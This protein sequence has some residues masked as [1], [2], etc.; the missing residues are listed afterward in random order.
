[1]VC[2]A[3]DSPVGRLRLAA[4][5]NGLCL[6]AFGNRADKRELQ[7]LA[8][9]CGCSPGKET[10]PHLQRGI[11]E[12]E[13]YFAAGLRDFIV[14]LDLRGTPFQIKVWRELLTIP[15]GRTLSYGELARR[16][17]QPNAQRAVGQAVGANPVAIIIP[18]HRVISA[19]GE[20][21]G[22]GGGLWRK[23]FLLEHERGLDDRRLAVH[24]GIADRGAALS[25]VGRSA[26]T[27]RTGR[28]QTTGSGF[29]C[30]T[31]P[32]AGSS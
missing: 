11:E 24:T 21:H 14:P 29:G 9:R 26:P 15:F 4:T 3:I 25:P 12:L 7:E 17:G 10:N 1:M 31:S 22:F 28:R 30:P 13:A 23:G 16:I 20:L 8:G 27:R 18:C 32:S 2:T 5:E 6:V 19:S